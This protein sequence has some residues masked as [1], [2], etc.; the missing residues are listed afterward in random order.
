VK[1]FQFLLHQVDHVFPELTLHSNSGL[2]FGIIS[3]GS[4]SQWKPPVLRFLR[5]LQL[6]ALVL[7]QAW[8]R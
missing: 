2:V 3:K 6:P 5:T 1:A 4:N 8:S 7:L